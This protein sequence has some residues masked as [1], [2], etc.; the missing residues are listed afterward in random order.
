MKNKE[1]IPNKTSIKNMPP[2]VC[3][4]P[5]LSQNKPTRIILAIVLA[6]VK[7]MFGRLFLRFSFLPS[8]FKKILSLTYVVF[9]KYL[10][11]NGTP[12]TVIQN[13]SDARYGKS[14]SCGLGPIIVK[15]VIK[16]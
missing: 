2:I 7:N 3:G 9:E 13:T 8:L 4:T 12:K 6:T 11:S 5:C 15:A 14:F 1:G 16:P 10:T